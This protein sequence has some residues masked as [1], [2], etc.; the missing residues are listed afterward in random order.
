MDFKFHFNG[1]ITKT[2][3]QKRNTRQ[4]HTL[5]ATVRGSNMDAHPTAKNSTASYAK[6]TGKENTINHT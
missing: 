2:Q 1:Q 4:L 5:S 3:N 6:E